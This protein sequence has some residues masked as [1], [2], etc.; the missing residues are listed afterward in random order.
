MAF[1]IDDREEKTNEITFGKK[2]QHLTYIQSTCLGEEERRMKSM[3]ER[4]IGRGR[5]SVLFSD[6]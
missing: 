1:R 5:K 4:K 3:I 2:S 6:F